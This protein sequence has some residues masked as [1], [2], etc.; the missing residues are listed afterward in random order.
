M[1]EG[2]SIHVC[3]HACVMT[4]RLKSIYILTFYNSVLEALG[5]ENVTEENQTCV[6]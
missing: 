4:L 3:M 1:G 6:C 5:Y 2:G